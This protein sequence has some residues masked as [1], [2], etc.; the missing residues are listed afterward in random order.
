MCGV[1]ICDVC[2]CPVSVCEGVWYVC[3]MYVS[4]NVYIC[5][6]SRACVCGVCG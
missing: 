6:H 2:M 4:V 3:L 1:C 5:V